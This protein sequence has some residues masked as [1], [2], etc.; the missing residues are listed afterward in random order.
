MQDEKTEMS[1]VVIIMAELTQKGYTTQFKATE[2]GL[3]SMSTQKIF[4]PKQI[5]VKHFYRFEG[6]SDPNDS[7]IVY[8]IE[9]KTGEKGTLVDSYGP[10]C[11]PHVSNFIKKVENFQK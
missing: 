3:C 11:D 4:K 9:T 10:Y 7:S 5:E 2:K 8:A 1:P 6:E